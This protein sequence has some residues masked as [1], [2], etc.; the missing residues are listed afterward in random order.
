MASTQKLLESNKAS[1]RNLLNAITSSTQFRAKVAQFPTNLHND[2]DHGRHDPKVCRVYDLAGQEEHN[3]TGHWQLEN[4]KEIMTILENNED[5][6][7]GSQKLSALAFE[8]RQKFVRGLILHSLDFQQLGDRHAA[9]PKAHE[10]TFGWIFQTGSNPTI[11]WSDFVQWLSVDNEGAHLY[12]ISGKPGSGKSTL[13]RYLYDAQCT[14]QLLEKWS[15]GQKLLIAS[16]FFWNAGSFIQKSLTGL[17]RAILHELLSHCPDLNHIVCPWRWQSYELGARSLDPWTVRELLDP[18]QLFVEHSSDSVRLCIFVDGLDEF[19]GDDRARKEIIDLFKT[20][21]RHRHVKV[22]VSSRP[23]LIFADEFHGSPSLLLQDLT[24]ND[25]KRYVQTELEGNER[26]RALKSRDGNGCSQL[27]LGIVDKAAGVFL[28]VYLVVRSLLEGLR[29]EDD[30]RDLRRRLDS[31]P[32]DLEKYFTQMMN[33]LSPFYLEQATTLFIIALH[34]DP[35]LSLMAYSFFNEEDPNYALKMEVKVMSKLEIRKRHE[36]TTR[37]LNSRCKGLLEVS[38]IDG[39]APPFHRQVDFLHRTARDFMRTKS[40]QNMLAR[41]T[42]ARFDAG[43]TIMS[44]YLV[45][46]KGL[47]VGNVTPLYLHSPL[48]P[49]TLMLERL[50]DCACEYEMSKGVAPTAILDDLDKSAGLLFQR[51]SPLRKASGLGA[52]YHWS[53]VRLSYSEGRDKSPKTFITLA[54]SA[55]LSLYIREAGARSQLGFR[56]TR[57]VPC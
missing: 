18:F 38:Q 13:M 54:T 4:Y 35:P 8:E 24:Y 23:W 3:F 56:A 15:K 52:Y 32:T 55:G 6:M 30:T 22:C 29:D 25:I 57:D 20:I 1:E 12:W 10:E 27:I 43:R 44:S 21:S 46:I 33:T 26:F 47:K 48:H 17:L 5:A 36:S 40:M 7:I 34:A 9:I 16:C 2:I 42:P 45:Q 31:L 14:R 37:R 49:F 39:K 50:F 51:D 19:E 11:R 41:Y 53:N 28:W